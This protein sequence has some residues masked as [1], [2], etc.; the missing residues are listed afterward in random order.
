MCLATAELRF[1]SRGAGC[2][3]HGRRDEDGQ[4]KE[5]VQHADG[6]LQLHPRCDPSGKGVELKERTHSSHKP[7]GPLEGHFYFAGGKLAD[8]PLWN[9]MNLFNF[10]EDAVVPNKL[11]ARLGLQPDGSVRNTNVQ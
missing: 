10:A 8:I 5:D 2:E 3:A 7:Y 6:A 1:V 9:F 4:G 11:A